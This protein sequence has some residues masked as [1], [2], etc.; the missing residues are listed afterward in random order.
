MQAFSFSFNK[1]GEIPVPKRTNLKNFQKSEPTTRIRIRE[2][3]RD[4][5]TETPNIVHELLENGLI[6]HFAFVLYSIYRR[7]AGEHGECWVGQRN[8]A[9]KCG[10][11]RPTV[12]RAKLELCKKFDLLGGKS[13]IINTRGNKKDEE[14]DTVEIEDIWPENY[15]HFKKSLTWLSGL[16]PMVNGRATH[17]SVVDQKNEPT[18]K[19]P[20]KNKERTIDKNIHKSVNSLSASQIPAESSLPF[21]RKDSSK[22]VDFNDE[23]LHE[24]LNLELHYI[25]F[26]RP[27]IVSRWIKKF[28]PRKTLDTIK[29]LLKTMK[30]T[31]KKIENPEAWMETALKNNFTD[32]NS[33]I[34]ENK[35]FAIKFKKDHGLHNLSINKRYCSDSKEQVYYH[36]PHE[37]FQE[38]MKKVFLTKY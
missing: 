34:E 10:F 18:K 23:V 8:L 4:Y 17:G 5:R 16:P 20:Y 37:Q 38:V 28:G 29:L 26:F 27:N 11:S 24:I 2:V 6:S 12:Q 7:I 14:A 31:K 13:L 21:Q 25:Q 35:Q 22:E 19:E 33:Q 3:P 9:K 36:L 1:Q 30:T 15:A 32:S